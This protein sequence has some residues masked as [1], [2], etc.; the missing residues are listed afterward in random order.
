MSA[1]SM[2]LAQSFV[3]ITNEL[4]QALG[5]EITAIKKGAGTHNYSLHDG[6]LKG[7]TGRRFTYTF[8]LGSELSVPNDSP[9]RLTVGNET[10]DAMVISLEGSEISISVNVDLGPHVPK[11][12]LNVEPYFL[13]EILQR[14]LEEAANGQ[15]S[16]NSEMALKL[17]GRSSPK[18]LAV[19]RP[20]EPALL[21]ELNQEQ[22]EA[23]TRSL[24][25]EITFIWGP[26]GTGKTRTV[27]NLVRLLADRGERVLV[28]SHTNAAVDAAIKPVVQ[29]L[30]PQDVEDGAVVRIGEPQLQDPEVVNNTL[31]AVVDRKGAQLRRR[32]QDLERELAR[33]QSEQRRIES[34]IAAYEAVHRAGERVQGLSRSVGQLHHQRAGIETSL[35]S[36]AN[37]IEELE[38]QLTEAEHMGFV[39]RIISRRNPEAIR[40]KIE[41][42]RQEM[43]QLAESRDDLQRRITELEQQI[44]SAQKEGEEAAQRLKTLG[45]LPPA[46]E[47]E[48]TRDRLRQDMAQQEAS[49]ARVDRELE[50]LELRVLEEA[51]VI[52]ATLFRL[53]LTEDLYSKP[54]DTVIVDEASM[55]PLT[56]L[57]FAAMLA[58]QR[59]VITGDF[60]QL[61]P[62][63]NAND[64]KKY[65]MAARWLRRDA[66]Q[67]AGVVG[68]DGL[69][70]LQ[71]H[72][73]APL[74][75]QYR[76]HP[77]IGDLVNTLV[78]S[79]DGH[80]LEHMA[81]ERELQPII[82]ALPAPGSPLV[83]CNT[84]QVN[85]WCAREPHGYSRYNIYSAVTSVRLAAAA[86]AAGVESVGVVAPYRLQVQLMATLVQEYGLPREQVEVATVH[87]F[88]GGERDVIVLDLV[89]GPPYRIGRLMKG[90]FPTEASR[91]INVACSRAK[92]KLIVVAHTR[93]LTTKL[94]PADSL[95]DLL[96]YM[97]RYAHWLDASTVVGDYAEA[98][99]QK[100]IETFRK[101]A[102]LGYP[103]GA[104]WHNETTFYP[105]FHQDLQLA[106]QRIT[107]YSPYIHANRMADVMPYLRAAMDRGVGV[108][109]VTRKVAPNTETARLIKEIKAAG[110]TVHEQQYLHEKLAF[111]DDQVAWFGSLNSLSQ[112]S[113]TEQMMRFNKPDL[114]IKLMELS[115]IA[116]TIR[117]QDKHLEQK[118]RR[119]RLAEALA[120]RVKPPVCPLCSA[121]TSLESWKY[122][123][124]YACTQKSCKGF[125]NIQK[126][127]LVAAV[128]ELGISCP[129]CANG[130]VK[131]KYR[132]NG[133]FLSCSRYPDCKW[134]DSY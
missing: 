25:Q 22:R 37:S 41:N 101:P 124:V 24:G 80:P 119:E 1:K 87:R 111:I 42:R 131:A 17:F 55:V 72:R 104:T 54:F 123:P 98:D 23:V 107:I 57:W 29:H 50:E 66:F 58:K 88:Q 14:R 45:D 46:G 39:Q 78:Y 11:A 44:A 40:R 35:A 52:G 112:R 19:S 133:A 71:D 127:A 51:R 48:K 4:I 91:L 94:D 21:A 67:E 113:S 38:A 61:A 121:P 108:T 6:R 70:N 63:A 130:V 59:V 77:S 128:D 89:D 7:V 125:V 84:S 31:Q 18:A 53:V 56:N 116:G 68:E 105:A 26:P 81:D 93:H 132:K 10:Y 129:Q 62:I 117:R 20:A 34:A 9:A 65:P 83:L 114:V 85:P 106:Q 122:G 60:R 43:H 76:M 96:Q 90:G 28:T 16:A 115:G 97:G 102:D 82:N 30:P 8:L 15:I 86:L 118:K 126:P 109:I 134:S 103:D 92:A 12:L 69:V 120:R 73:L 79:K 47:L 32:R 110:A 99:I 64:P 36:R 13:L 27:G 5:E 95:T 74:S 2:G 49:I 100:A 75:K 3:E 33:L